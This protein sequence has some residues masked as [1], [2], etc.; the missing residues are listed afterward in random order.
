ME[1]EKKK[2]KKKKKGKKKDWRASGS[3]TVKVLVFIVL[4][5]SLVIERA[6]DSRGAAT[7][8]D[9]GKLKSTKLI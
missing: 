7:L 1:S 3:N 4:G 6:A 8:Q 2:K 9:T 5:R